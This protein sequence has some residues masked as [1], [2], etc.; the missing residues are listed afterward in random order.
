MAE[1]KKFTPKARLST[2][3]MDR[4][5]AAAAERFRS[6]PSAVRNGQEPPSTS[7]PGIGKVVLPGDAA[8]WLYL[9]VTL[10]KQQ[11]ATFRGVLANAGI[12]NNVAGQAALDAL[13]ERTIATHRATLE[14]VAARHGA[15]LLDEEA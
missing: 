12:A 10:P 7:R 11:F 13:I 3:A 9:N 2:A 1:I 6:I 8:R 4:M 5:A 15:T 14:A